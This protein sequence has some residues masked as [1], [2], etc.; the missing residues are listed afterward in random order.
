VVKISSRSRVVPK[1]A[2]QVFMAL[3]VWDCDIGYLAWLG[4]PR[5]GPAAARPADA[6]FFFGGGAK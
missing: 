3:R 2:A 6:A 1:Q 5:I 4:Y